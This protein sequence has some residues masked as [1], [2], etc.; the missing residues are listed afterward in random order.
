ML[1][2]VVSAPVLGTLDAWHVPAG[3]KVLP[4]NFGP[5]L[6]QALRGRLREDG[7]GAGAARVRGLDQGR[8]VPGDHPDGLAVL[9]QAASRGRARPA[10]RTGAA[11]RGSGATARRGYAAAIR[12]RAA[13][14][15]AGTATGR[16][17]AA[18]CRGRAAAGRD[19]A[20]SRTGTAASRGQATDGLDC[21][22]RRTA[23]GCTTPPG[24]EPEPVAPERRRPGGRR[25]R[26]IGSRR[27]SPSRRALQTGDRRP[28]QRSPSDRQVR[29]EVAATGPASAVPA[30]GGTGHG[31]RR[32]WGGADGGSWAGRP[33]GS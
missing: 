30:T 16:D 31:G 21:A 26:T 9:H 20:T 13:A 32:S 3:P 18:A 33:G 2:L 22:A 15:R 11:H 5:H 25:N 12:S 7:P 23:D 1:S 24:H 14:I 8:V 17:R 29:A 19:Q 10:A 6:A 4:K 28:S 27:P